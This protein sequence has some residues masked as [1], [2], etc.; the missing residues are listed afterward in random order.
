MTDRVRLTLAEAESLCDRALTASNVSNGNAR[1]TAKALVAAEADG[2]KGHG[3]S[4]IPSYA[5]QARSGKVDGK[6]VPVL[7]RQGAA[8]LRIDA[9]SGFAYPAIELACET[10]PDIASLTGVASACIHNS[11]HLGQAGAH[12]ERLANSGLVALLFSNSPKAINF[13]GGRDPM[14][15][16]NP[17]AFAAPRAASDP[18]VIDLAL[19]KVARGKILAAKNAGE[20]IPDTWALDAKGIATD[21]PGAALQGSMLPIGDAKGA[22]L[23]LIVELLSAA[24]TG[25]RFGYEA[26]SFFEATGDAPGIG[27][28]IIVFE[29]MMSSGGNFLQRMDD[30]VA[31]IERTDGARLPGATRLENRHKAVKEG[32]LIPSTLYDEI[33]SIIQA[34]P[35]D[36]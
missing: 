8:L 6:A 7:E 24:L 34:E 5:A 19:S 28:T 2:Q 29:P 9:K 35:V 16:T 1:L 4:R 18:L 21:D 31:M 23:V 27:H 33:E 15:G 14:M 30:I 36:G 13:W 20:K 26:S 10:L 12:A 22:A 11:H 3:L 17:I 32:L 25:A